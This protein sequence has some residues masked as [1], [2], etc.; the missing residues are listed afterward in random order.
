MT[1]EEFRQRMETAARDCADDSEAVH[2]A[3]DAIMRD[4]LIK[5]GY[6]DGIA[7]FDRCR[8]WYS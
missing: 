4:C 8:K 2:I 3:L 1:P 6:S 5:L 7:V